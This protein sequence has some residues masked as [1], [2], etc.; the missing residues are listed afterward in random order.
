MGDNT[1]L[2][3][4]DTELRLGKA[5]LRRIFDTVD[6]AQRVGDTVDGVLDEFLNIFADY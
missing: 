1:G 5:K 3:D 6:K 2:R 4:Y